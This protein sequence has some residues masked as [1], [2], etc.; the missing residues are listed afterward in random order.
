MIN[1]LAHNLHYRREGQIREILQRSESRTGRVEEG[2]ERDGQGGE[3]EVSYHTGQE[4]IGHASS[5]RV[6]RE[7]CR[8]QADSPSIDEGYKRPDRQPFEAARRLSDMFHI[9]EHNEPWNPRLASSS[10]SY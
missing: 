9:V 6:A 2:T 7:D 1:E 5:S 10:N 3:F 4:L 8:V